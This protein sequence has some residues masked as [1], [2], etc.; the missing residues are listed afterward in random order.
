MFAAERR[1]LILQLVQASGAVS[2]RDLAAAAGSSEV[3][4]RRDVRALEDQGL[5]DRRHGG[6]V[7][8]G[9]LAHEATYLQKRVVAA[10]EKA[11]IARL[12]ASMVQAGDAVV[13]G[14]GTT[15]LELSRRL[16]RMA[17]LTVVT[18]S[19]LVAETLAAAPVEV[20]LT[21]G[22]LRGATFA[23]VGSATEQSLSGLRV[24][25]A[26]LSGNGLSPGHGLS[27]PN[28]M[29]ASVDRAIV[30]AAQEVV[31]VVDHTKLGVDTMFQTIPPGEITHLV[32]DDRADPAVLDQFAAMGVQVRVAAVPAQPGRSSPGGG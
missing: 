16:A 31:V 21:G 7:R 32:T 15:T 13:I 23:L 2:L 28:M 8:V 1:Q 19:I 25:R 24:Q 9:G 3:T 4:I 5:L 27:T 10:A 29:V 26:F 11:A 12:A 30:R 14:A 6:A 20:V 18:N 22:I 17:D